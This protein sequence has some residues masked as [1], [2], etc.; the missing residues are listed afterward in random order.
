MDNQVTMK[1]PPAA[2][3]SPG[4]TLTELLIVILIIFGLTTLLVPAVRSAM[5]K[6]KQTTCMNN[7]KQL[8][9]GFQLHAESNDDR[10][11]QAIH[12]ANSNWVHM[13]AARFCVAGKPPKHL[14]WQPASRGGP[15]VCNPILLCPSEK[16]RPLASPTSLPI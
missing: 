10:F 3:R 5:E 9:T 1:I 13:V 11:P 12:P 15:G 8:G 7:L 16:N 6:A 4:F 14:A 2:R